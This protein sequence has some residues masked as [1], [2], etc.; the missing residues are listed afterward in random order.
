MIADG[1]LLDGVPEDVPYP[2]KIKRRDYDNKDGNK[3]TKGLKSAYYEK[4]LYQLADPDSRSHPYSKNC[5]IP[6]GYK[7]PDSSGLKVDDIIIR[8][9]KTYKQNGNENGGASANPKDLGTFGAL[10]K[11]DITTPGFIRLPENAD[12]IDATRH[13]DGFPYNNDNSKSYYT[14]SKTTY[15]EETTS[16]SP[17]ID[18]CL[19]IIKNIE[20]TSGSWFRPIERQYGI[21]NHRIYT[22]GIKGK[23][24]K[25]NADEYIGAQDAVDIIRYTAKH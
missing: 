3:Y 13:K 20:G 11:L 23:G 4:R 16:E 25:G 22:F 12:K 6:G 21:L 19:V 1:R 17:L 18:D 9:V 14:T 10:K 7:C 5:G 24:R 15:I 2:K 8:S